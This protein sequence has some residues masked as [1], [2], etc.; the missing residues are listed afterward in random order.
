MLS[1]ASAYHSFVS[2][3]YSTNSMTAAADY[4]DAEAEQLSF[5]TA[6]SVP[7]LDGICST[8]GGDKK[9]V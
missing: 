6:C 3:L 7:T 4:T 5:W 9:C 1:G 8:Y 2:L